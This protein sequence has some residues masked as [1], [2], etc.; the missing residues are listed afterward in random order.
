[1]ANRMQALGLVVGVFLAGCATSAAQPPA[2]AG[3]RKDGLARVAAAAADG[4]CLQSC[5]LDAR[6]GVYTECLAEG[7]EQRACGKS[8]RGWYRDCIESSCSDAE[9]Q[10]D[11]CRVECRTTGAA[12]RDLCASSDQDA[13]SC[14][15]DAK[16]TAKACVAACG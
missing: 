1:M 3:E 15:V 6:A 16:A 13:D 4:S 12:A 10:L 14:V 2:D 8:A 7:G 9:V 5:G 11:S